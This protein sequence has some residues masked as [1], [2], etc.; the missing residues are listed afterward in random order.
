MTD[1]AWLDERDACSESSSSIELTRIH[2][3]SAVQIFAVTLVVSGLD[4]K[5]SKFLP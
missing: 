3:S 4:E 2:V 1:C 5:N